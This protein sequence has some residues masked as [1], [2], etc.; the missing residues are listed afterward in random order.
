MSRALK[1]IPQSE[2][3]GQITESLVITQVR[4]WNGNDLLRHNLKGWITGLCLYYIDNFS[5]ATT[6]LIMMRSKNAFSPPVEPGRPNMAIFKCHQSMT[7]C[8]NPTN[9]SCGCCYGCLYCSC[10][11]LASGPC[12]DLSLTLFLPCLDLS[13]TLPWTCPDLVLTLSWLYLDLTLP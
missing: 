13:L 12:L 2:D 7:R 3:R 8:Q 11:V 1:P 6:M 4:Y 10:L 5:K 9:C